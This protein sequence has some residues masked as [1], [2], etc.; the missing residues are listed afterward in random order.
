MHSEVRRFDKHGNLIGTY[1][2]KQVGKM[3]WTAFYRENVDINFS[4]VPAIPGYTKQSRM[5]TKI[6]AY[7]SPDKKACGKEFDTGSVNAK[8]CRDC[9]SKARHNYKPKERKT[10][11]CRQEA[12]QNTFIQVAA[13]HKYCGTKCKSL[14][15]YHKNRQRDEKHKAIVAQ[16]KLEIAQRKT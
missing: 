5:K 2:V 15:N 12:C 3:F 9:R 11:T 4:A 14:A 6:C 13:N 7:V 16:R 1:D 10:I 8:Y